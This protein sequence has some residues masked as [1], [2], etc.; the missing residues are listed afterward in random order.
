[1]KNQ[2]V[3]FYSVLAAVCVVF[4]ILDYYMCDLV[5]YQLQFPIFCDMCFCMAMTFFAGPLWGIFVVISDHIFDMIISHSFVVEQLY[6]ASAFFGCLA[7]WLYKK[8]AM[9]EGESLFIVF[10]RLLLLVLIMTLVMSITGGIISR[11]VAYF[12]ADGTEYTYQVEFLQLLFG[13]KIKSPLL[14]AILLRLPV[15]LADRFITVFAGWGI[16]MGMSKINETVRKRT[17]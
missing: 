12:R 13:G 2:T 1:M 4:G 16:F 7:A 8:Y 11:I 14:D 5:V 10:S 3:T 6:M 9:K 17:E 15:N